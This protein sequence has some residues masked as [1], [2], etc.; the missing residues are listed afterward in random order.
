M[1]KLLLI[2]LLLALSASTQSGASELRTGSVAGTV[3]D[4]TSNRPLGHT[5]LVVLETGEKVTAKVDGTFAFENLPAGSYTIR[6]GC[7]DHWPRRV[8]VKV[9]GRV[10]SML[11]VRLPVYRGV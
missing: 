11:T 3:V 6:A 9:D 7:N 4:S 5:E 2:C 1:T 10:S 8:H